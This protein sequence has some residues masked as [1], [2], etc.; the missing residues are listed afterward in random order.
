MFKLSKKEMALVLIIAFLGFLFSTRIWILYL[1]SLSP[2][3]GLMLY[4]VLMFAILFVLSKVGL[5]V[6]SVRIGTTSQIIGTMLV[7]FGFF[8]VTNWGESCLT[9]YY[10]NNNCNIPSAYLQ[11]E[12]GALWNVWNSSGVTD[13]ELLRWLT[14]VITPAA[15]ALFGGMLTIGRVRIG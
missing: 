8:A 3:V 7:L 6:G 11:T 4:Y 5:I 14:Y 1:N 9:S 10:V 2:F 13:V 12:D 15:L